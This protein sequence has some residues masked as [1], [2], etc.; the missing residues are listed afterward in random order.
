M[1]VPKIFEGIVAEDPT[2]D[3]GLEADEPQTGR[4]LVREILG[5][6]NQISSE[7]LL[8]AYIVMPTVS[9]GVSGIGMSP[10]GL[11]K[12][13]RVMCMRL[14][15]EPSAYIIGV[16][17]YAPEDN[18]SVSSYARGQGEPELKTRNRIKGEDRVIEPDSKYKAKYPYNN[19]TTRSGHIVEFDDTPDSERVQIFHKSGSYIEILPDGT[20][21]TKSVKD[22]IQLA[23]GNIS[24]FNQGEEDGGKDIEITSNQG[25]IIITAQK[26]VSI[27]ANEGNV[28]IFANNGTVSVTS[29]S[30]AVDI[31]AAI[32]GINA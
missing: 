16:L 17:N 5:H 6:S 8:P 22:H 31:Q 23:F 18:H 30:G 2:S 1:Q 10:T 21:V 7:N 25:E 19:M 4:V 13:S 28:G 15:D 9:A 29:K 24:I 27:F 32:V 11:L 3:L 26:D 14:P 20:I 12:G